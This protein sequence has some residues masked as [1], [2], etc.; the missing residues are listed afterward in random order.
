[1]TTQ[2]T[3]FQ[4]NNAPTARTL[5]DRLADIKNVRDFDA[6]GD[7]VTDD[8]SAIMAAMNWRAGNT[9]RG[10]VYF[11]PGTHYVSGPIDLM[12]RMT[13]IRA[14]RSFPWRNR[15]LNRHWRFC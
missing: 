8:C 1:M 2:F 4:A 3:A 7:G 5:P 6:V 15:S 12:P 13:S 10:T 9:T 14:I 11:P